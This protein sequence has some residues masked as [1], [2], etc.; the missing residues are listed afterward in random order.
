MPN[1]ATSST[2]PANSF[3][4]QL[5]QTALK[6]IQKF[7]GE[8]D[9]KVSQFITAI[10][11]IGSFTK[12]NDSALHA[13]AT[14]K[15]GGAA[16]NWY[17]NNKEGLTTWSSLRTHLLQRFQ[18]SKSIAKTQLKTRTQQPGEALASFYDAIIDLCK[19]VDTQMPLYLI[20]D[21]LQDG[22]RD[23]LKI[24][25]KR[26]LRTLDTEIT[27][28]VF[29]K[30][31]RDEEELQKEVL[32]SSN[33]TSLPQPYFS[34]VVA[35]TR[36][37]PTTSKNQSV[38]PHRSMNRGFPTVTSPP[39]TGRSI[40]RNTLMSQPHYRPC[41]ICNRSNHRTI[42][43]YHKYPSGC[44]KCGGINHSIRDCPQVFQ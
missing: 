1:E 7:T 23:D 13:L 39:Q 3:L 18:P 33:V 11:H 34:T 44:F 19:Q 27:P 6:E 22:V 10:E 31:A 28:A 32:S 25:I 37:P 17:D 29:L 43:C 24:H 15:L 8:S 35:A 41:L 42:D 2:A 26:R 38:A 21:Y 12:L 16:F 14:I 5:Q 36:T 40:F 20:V 30:I 4:T 9:E